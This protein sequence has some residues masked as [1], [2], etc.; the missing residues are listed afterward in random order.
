[1]LAF[2]M[3]HDQSEILQLTCGGGVGNATTKILVANED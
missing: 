2:S 1:M 3:V